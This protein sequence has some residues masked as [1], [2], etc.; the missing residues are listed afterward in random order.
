MISKEEI[1]KLAQLARIDISNE[2]KDS[3]RTDIES[4][5][6]YVGQVK[7]ISVEA[8]REMPVP[9]NVMRDDVVT[10]QSGE[11]TEDLLAL[12]PAR[13]GNYLKVK[14]IL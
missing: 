2:E 1:E 14:K 12:A 10:H 11:F 13:E 9:R 6:E 5:L 8:E 4:I 7:N 3:M